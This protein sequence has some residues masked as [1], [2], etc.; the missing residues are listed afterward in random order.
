MEVRD[1]F[2][3]LRM[4]AYQDDLSFLRIIN[5]PRRKMGKTRLTYLRC[6]AEAEGL[7]LYN[8]LIKHKHDERFANTGAGDF[9]TL[10]ERFRNRTMLPS[11][12]MQQLLT[13]SGYESYIRENGDMER[14]DN[15]AELL[16]AVTEYE[17]SFGEDL[18]L[19]DYLSYVALRYDESELEDNRDFVQ[20]MTIHA[21]KG[22]EFPCVF[23]MGMSEG[24]SIPQRIRRLWQWKSTKIA[25]PFSF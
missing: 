10:I 9:I 19:E 20:L 12:L 18:K 17:R 8:S 24:M 4:A 14:L 5:V 22:L 7:S 6:C 15:L 25:I 1:A 2:A 21:S 13:E 16:K 23:I 3:Y 11:D